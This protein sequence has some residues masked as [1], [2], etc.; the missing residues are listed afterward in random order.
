M[1]GLKERVKSDIAWSIQL[2]QLLKCTDIFSASSGSPITM[3]TA[4]GNLKQPSIIICHLVF[5]KK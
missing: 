2:L 3:W 4:Q 1:K 5:T